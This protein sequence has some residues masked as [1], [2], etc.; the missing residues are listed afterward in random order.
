MAKV[1]HGRLRGRTIELTEDLGLAEGQEVEVSVRTVPGSPTRK[2]GEG[3]G[4]TE[5]ALADDPH[6]DDLMAEEIR[7][8]LASAFAAQAL[9]YAPNDVRHPPF[10]HGADR[11]Q[12]QRAHSARQ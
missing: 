1:V 8:S 9:P 7:R 10:V 5:G 4:R 12:G 3:F 2:P 6:W 11:R